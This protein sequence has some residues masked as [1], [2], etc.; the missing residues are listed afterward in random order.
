MR[1]EQVLGPVSE[2]S[3][4]GKIILGHFRAGGGSVD[5]WQVSDRQLMADAVTRGEDALELMRP[6]AARLALRKELRRVRR[7]LEND[8]D[9]RERKGTIV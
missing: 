3:D 7:L 9:R 1:A 4:I 5:R 2:D 8:L 6:S